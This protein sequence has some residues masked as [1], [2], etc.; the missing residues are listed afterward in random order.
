M[1]LKETPMSGWHRHIFTIALLVAGSPAYAGALW[2]SEF[3]SP[4]DGRAGA[5]ANAGTDDAATV[6]HNPAAMSR[7]KQSELMVTGG[8]VSSDIEFDVDQG[9]LLN[10]NRG[11]GDAGDTIPAGSAFY[12]HPHNDQWSFG[13][14]VAALTGG[15]FDY[16]SDWV[17]RFQAVEVDLIGIAVVPAVSYKMNEMIS[18]GVGL[19]VMYSDLELKIALPNFVAGP[20]GRAKLDGDDTEVAFSLSALVE[21][22]ESTRVGILYQ[23]EFE[24]D[25]GGDGDIET[26]AGGVS[27]AVST[28]LTMAPIVHL[29]GVHELTD[30]LTA[31]AVVGW[32]GWSKMDDIIISGE[33]TFTLPREWDDTWKFGLGLEYHVNPSWTLNTGITY[34][35]DPTNAER[36]TA[37]MPMDEQWRYSFGAVHTRPSGMKIGASLTYADYGSAEIERRDTLPVAGFSGEYEDN[38]II[39]FSINASWK[40]GE[41]RR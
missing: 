28:Q 14:G 11:S 18:V 15:V 12:V 38:Q 36:R 5:G 20:E 39:F 2:L 31:H 27:T 4:S 37:D 33:N 17:G 16:E 40:L 6:F 29:G 26:S 22:S 13:I 23:S 7:L 30:S 3:G 35:T 34:D 41:R 24:F 25:Y 32:E 10:G 9:S 21:F 19:P 1:P 8:V